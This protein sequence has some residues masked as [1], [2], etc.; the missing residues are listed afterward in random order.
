MAVYKIFAEADSTIYSRYPTK[1]AGLDEILEISVK[2][3]DH[4][5]NDREYPG[6]QP[7]IGDDIRR[8]VIKFSDDDILTL[9]TLKSLDYKVYLKSYIARAENLAKQYTLEFRPLV[10]QWE[11][12]TGHFQDFPDNKT[13]VSWYQSGAYQCYPNGLPLITWGTSYNSGVGQY[14]YFLTSGG[15]TWN[16][17]IYSTQS[18]TYKSSKDIEADVTNIYDYWIAGAENNG[19]IIK[20]T[21]QV[22]NS[23]GSFMVL[24]YFSNDT[25]TIYPPTLEM[26]WN[27][28]EY[29]VGNLQTI[30]DSNTIISIANNVGSYNWNKQVYKFRINARDKYPQ[31]VF[32][33]SSLYTTNKALPENSYWS[34]LDA[35]TN[36]IVVGFDYQY[37]KISCD[38]TSSYFMMYMNG[39]EPE[40][41]YKLLIQ[42]ELPSG[43]TIDWDSELIFKVTK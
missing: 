40:R 29:N 42:S 41:Y 11:M 10:K 3:N 2:N 30:Y 7:S 36:D 9:E 24:N 19:I 1:N 23:S 28:S 26:R 22:E 8:S 14:S 33:T 31:R 15:G 35:K 17:S 4:P 37:T 32:T 6:T 13:G 21:P 38:P 34:L 20:H 18:F 16:S 12:G 27:D 39:L 25:H 43:E 5:Y